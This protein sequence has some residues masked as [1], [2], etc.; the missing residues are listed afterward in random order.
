[1]TIR[2]LDFGQVSPIASQAIYHGLADAL[3]ADDSPVITL[4]SPSDPYICVGALQDARLE[5]DEGYCRRHGLPVLRREIGGGAVYLD[6]HQLFYHFVFPR[7]RAPAAALD[8]FPWFIEP[9][10]R[11]YR[12]LGIAARLPADQ[13]HPRGRPQDRRDRRRAGS[14]RPPCWGAASCSTSTPPPWRAA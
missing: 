3:R 11:T 5:V 10:L 9:V 12:G 1:M 2:V 14:A 13:R 4:C 8:L 6:R 7:H